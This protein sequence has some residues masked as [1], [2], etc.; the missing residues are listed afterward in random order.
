[1]LLFFLVLLLGVI[2]FSSE[3][4]LEKEFCSVFVSNFGSTRLVAKDGLAKTKSTLSR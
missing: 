4:P 1:M 3:Q 2:T